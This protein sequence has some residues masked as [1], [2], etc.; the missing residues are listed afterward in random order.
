MQE[1]LFEW[2]EGRCL[3]RLMCMEEFKVL[4]GDY[5][6][7][8]NLYRSMNPVLYCKLETYGECI[9]GTMKI[10]RG[11]KGQISTQDFGFYLRGHELLLIGDGSLPG[12][13]VGKLESGRYGVTSPSGL[14]LLLFELLIEDDV[15]Y[16]G[17]QEAALSDMEEQLLGHLPVNF[18]ET[19]I[20]Y[21]KQ[22]QTYHSYYEQLADIGEQMQ[23]DF[24]WELTMEERTAWQLYAN[25]ALRL[26]DHT[27]RLREDLIQIRELYQSLID[28]QQNKVMS[29]LTVVTT[30]FLPLTLIAGWYGMNFP[31]M[32][33]FRWRYA[34]PVV[35]LVSVGIV[36][37]EI[38]FFRKKGML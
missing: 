35:I 38:M 34:Y 9:Q 24:G 19:I 17:A 29:I 33:E 10:P 6:Y 5:P 26:H 32:P 28:V 2:R 27:E 30:I 18:H 20:R 25:R 13:L 11:H 21:R 12:T 7:R 15:L 36:V 14:L 16:L 3:V 37:L 23:G 31:G 8:R 4:E 22:Y 1:Y